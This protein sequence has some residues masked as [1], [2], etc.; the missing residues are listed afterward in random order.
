M[1]Q[2]HAKMSKPGGTTWFYKCPL[3]NLSLGANKHLFWDHLRLSHR[4]QSLDCKVQNCQ[5]TCV[6]TQ[7]M[8][9]H[10]LTKHSTG[11][12][13]K[14]SHHITCEICARPILLPMAITHYVKDHYIPLDDGR[15]EVCGHC[16]E[17]FKTRRARML[18]INEIHLKISYDCDQCG[19]SFKRSSDQLRQHKQKVHM[20][21]SLRKQCQ[22][23]GKWLQDPEVL[24]NHIRKNHTGETPFK[25]V[26]C[27]VPFF[28][29]RECARHR[30][31][32]HPD[33]YG[34]DQNRKRW[35]YENQSKDPSEFKFKCLF[36]HETSS[37]IREF[38]TISELRQHWS[39]AHPGRADIPIPPNKYLIICE[40]CGVEMQSQTLLKIHTFEKHEVDKT[41]CPFCQEKFMT[42]EESL[43]HVKV[44][45]YSQNYYRQKEVCPQC[46]YVGGP[47]NM[48]HHM[49][50][51]HEKASIRPTACTYCNKE[52]SKYASMVKH[53]KIAHREQ[54]NKDKERIMVEEGGYSNSNDF[55]KEAEKRKRY[56]HKSACSICGRVLCSRTQLH[57]HMKALHGTGLPDY[58]PK[59]QAI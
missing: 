50:R 38:S 36:C 53:R 37:T 57:L 1:D 6:G 31:Y 51:M 29:A 13:S 52:F 4:E 8:T 33:S 28:S 21:E 12:I 26:F 45:K 40:L 10:N 22:V 25:C 16:G 15:R 43:E 48:K 32:N 55:L 54:W 19:K 41:E 44:H 7:L 34:A 46:G 5:Y 23:C 49:R 20:K 17:V 56:V 47:G 11:N 3:C 39:E 24:A 14:K 59:H 27:D 58:K 42:R 30:R 2:K 18:H 9:V 35:L